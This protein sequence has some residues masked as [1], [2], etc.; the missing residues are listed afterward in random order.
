MVTTELIKQLR[1]KTG[2]GVMEAKKVLD[3]AKGDMAKAIE[4][5][6][7]SGLAK[8]AKRADKTANQ[9]LIEVYSHAGKLGVI[10][11]VNC[12]TDFVARND[13]FKEFTHDLALHI[14]AMRPA[15][16]EELLEQDYVKD[17]K[18]K[19]QDLLTSLSQKTGEKIVINRFT[20]YGL[21]EE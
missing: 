11:E 20:V 9:G 15:N 10:V 13:T 17:P 4:L 3:E 5:L 19:I 6:K 2:V 21:G 14:A 12:E 16:V 1:E 18:H 7:E 8:V